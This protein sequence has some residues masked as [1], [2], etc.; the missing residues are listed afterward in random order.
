LEAIKSRSNEKNLAPALIIII[1]FIALI[2]CNKKQD[3]LTNEQIVRNYY[4]GLNSSDFNLI[5]GCVSDSVTY[6]DNGYIIAN[7]KKELYQFF[8]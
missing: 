6:A 2:A 5:S 4:T 3:N 1:S 7:N 8:K